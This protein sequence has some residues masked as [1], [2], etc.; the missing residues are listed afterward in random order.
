MLHHLLGKLICI[1]QIQAASLKDPSRA[2][3]HSSQQAFSQYLDD[4]SLDW[5]S[6]NAI[7]WITDLQ[8]CTAKP[9]ATTYHSPAEDISCQFSYR[10][11]APYV[12]RG[13]SADSQVFQGHSKVHSC[14]RVKEEVFTTHLPGQIG[15]ARRSR[16]HPSSCADAML[17]G[18]Q[19]RPL[20][21]TG[22]PA[23]YGHECDSTTTPPF[24][25]SVIS[26]TSYIAV[27]SPML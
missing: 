27:I 7:P 6:S 1:W 18:Y 2:K 23:I 25:M 10:I 21:I 4:K 16:A 13:P 3:Y 17:L 22:A 12:T 15:Q 11:G 9:L 19:S 8:L 14:E 20:F 5:H 24:P 26:L